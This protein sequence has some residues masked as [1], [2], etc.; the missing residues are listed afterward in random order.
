M[1]EFPP[2]VQEITTADARRC[3]PHVRIFLSDLEALD[4]PSVLAPVLSDEERARAS[5]FSS[6]AA[7]ASFIRRRW[8]RRRLLATFHGL[9]ERDVDITVDR[10]GLPSVVS[11]PRLRGFS[12]STSSSGRY[13]L[14]AWSK[15]GPLGV[16]I[17]EVNSEYVSIEAA[18]IFMSVSELHDWDHGVGGKLELFFQ[19]WTRKEA[20]LK[21]LGT[22]FSTDPTAVE[23]FASDRVGPSGVPWKAIG[24]PAPDGWVAALAVSSGT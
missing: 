17:A 10:L 1:S 18:Q 7:V 8:L 6:P 15:A 19:C 11:P 9:D 12:L 20:I 2:G 3:D 24:L 14:V 16:D 5:R 23:A 13:A 21:A 4:P 22:G